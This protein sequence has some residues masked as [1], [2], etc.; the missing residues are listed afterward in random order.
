M[1]IKRDAVLQNTVKIRGSGLAIRFQAEGL[2]NPWIWK[3][4]RHD[5]NIHQ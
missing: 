4:A 2:T 3:R 5:S 1:L